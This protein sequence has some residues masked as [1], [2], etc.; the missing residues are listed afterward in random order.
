[1]V[2]PRSKFDM[3]ST[4]F[5]DNAASSACV[6]WAASRSSFMRFP[7]CVETLADMLPI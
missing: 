4:D 1:M 5:R 7:I 3:V 6:S 2:L